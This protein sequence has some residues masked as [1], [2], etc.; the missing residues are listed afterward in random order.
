M[1]GQTNSSIRSPGGD[2]VFTLGPMRVHNAHL[3]AGRARGG[4]NCGVCET[5][6]AG[7]LA[8]DAAAGA[9]VGDGEVVESDGTDQEEA[10]APT[11]SDGARAWS[12]VLYS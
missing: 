5:G 10:A 6:L 11:S 4:K 8:P 7:V 12:S 3:Q 2:W 1:S 9:G